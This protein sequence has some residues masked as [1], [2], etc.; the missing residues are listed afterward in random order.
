MTFNVPCMTL[1]KWSGWSKKSPQS[2]K[3]KLLVKL[4]LVSW[5]CIYP[6][7]HVWLQSPQT[8]NHEEIAVFPPTT[9]G[10]EE[11]EPYGLVLQGFPTTIHT[12]IITKTVISISY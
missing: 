8:R 3:E 9:L 10:D 2:S 7:Y 4:C 5:M 1:V 6:V 11:N 12:H